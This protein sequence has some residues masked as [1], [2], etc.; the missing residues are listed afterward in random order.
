MSDREP[1]RARTRRARFAVHDGVARRRDRLRGQRAE[2]DRRARHV[3]RARDLARPAA[4]TSNVEIR[5]YEDLRVGQLHR[6]NRVARE[7]ELRGPARERGSSSVVPVSLS[8]PSPTLPVASNA[9]ARPSAARRGGLDTLDD[10]PPLRA[11]RRGRATR[12]RGPRPSAHR[13]SRRCRGRRER[14]RDL[15]ELRRQQRE[16]AEVG[17]THASRCRRSSSR[18]RARRRSAR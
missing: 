11:P 15:A 5:R 17:P 7:R 3:H 9:S 6:L 8:S 14:A 16:E 4:A 2:L 1:Q 13:R 18:A 12:L 10:E